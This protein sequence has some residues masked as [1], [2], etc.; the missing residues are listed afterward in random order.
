MRVRHDDGHSHGTLDTAQ[1]RNQH[2]VQV[3][4]LEPF[5]FLVANEQMVEKGVLGENGIPP[6]SDFPTLAPQGISETSKYRPRA[7]FSWKLSEQWG[8]WPTDY[9]GSPD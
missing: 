6:A 3:W 7:V 8:W 5:S 4:G 2:R 1:V 9:P